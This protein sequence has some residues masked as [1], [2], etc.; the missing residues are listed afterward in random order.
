VC[1]PS[2]LTFFVLTQSVFLLN[3]VTLN[4]VAPLLRMGPFATVRFIAFFDGEAVQFLRP[5]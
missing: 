3:V 2:M 5:N 4:V 1:P